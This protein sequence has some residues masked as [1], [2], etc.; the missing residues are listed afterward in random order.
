[1]EKPLFRWTPTRR[2]V[3][4]VVLALIMLAIPATRVFMADLDQVVRAHRE[5]AGLPAVHDL[6]QLVRM[7]Q[8]HRGL[9]NGMLSGNAALA[10]GTR[11][12]GKA[13]DQAL[14]QLTLRPLDEPRLRYQLNL[15]STHWQELADAVGSRTISP[16]ASFQRHTDLIEDELGLL[17]T[18]ADSTGLSTHQEPAGHYLQTAVLEHLPQ[19][20]ESLGRLRGEGTLILSRQ[21]ASLRDRVQLAAETERARETLR[22]VLRTLSL[23][24]LDRHAPLA[25][26]IADADAATASALE[27]ADRS[28]LQTDAPTMPAADYFARMTASID[29][30]FALIDT[31]LAT[32]QLR[33]QGVR[34]AAEA[35]LAVGALGAI[36]LACVGSW[37]LLTAQRAQKA[38]E[39][40]DRRL[41]S[42]IK[43]TPS[44]LFMADAG[45][46]IIEANP[47]ALA[48]FGDYHLEQPLGSLFGTGAAPV[49]LALPA[50][51]D[52]AASPIFVP[53]ATCQRVDGSSFIAELTWIPISAH[54]RHDRH[55]FLAVRDVTER[56]QLQQRLAQSQKMEAIG[57]LTGGIAHDFN[58]MLGVIL[59]NLDL[60]E[61][62]KCLD[63]SALKRIGTAQKAALRGAD[64]T[65]RLLAFS[66][67]Q[68]LD[69]TV[70]KLDEAI[71]EVVEMAARTLGADIHI[72]NRATADAPSVMVDAS[73]FENMLL[74]LLMNARDAMP[75][76]GLIDIA[77]S[78][79]D[80]DARHPAVQ[81]GELSPGRYAS[82]R[83]TDTGQGIAPDKLDKV[84]EPFFTTKQPG[85]GTGLGLAMV[86]G[87]IKQSGG[88]IKLYSE[89]GTGTTVQIILP[90]ADAAA[91]TAPAPMTANQEEHHA[92]PGAIA[93]V[94]DDEPDMRE[95]AAAYLED[96]GY[97][98]LHAGDA[99]DALRVL[100]AEPGISLLVTDVI[101]P[102]GMNGA[103]LG[104][105][106]HHRRPDI[107]V[108][109][110][111]GFPS[112]ALAR[113]NGTQVH[114]PLVSKPFQRQ[115]LVC[116]L[117]RTMDGEVAA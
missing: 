66:R 50:V 52:A 70:L 13:V 24:G 81:A 38:Q 62:S 98:V 115:E 16:E 74:N 65:R 113:R 5:V 69:P 109:Y 96:M 36:V 41:R 14:Q 111:S 37:L 19:L 51:A 6:L 26:A 90:L 47:A 57:Q 87:F 56:A 35:R 105:L 42:I 46:T 9:S 53:E 84:F 110:T 103:K 100:A 58:N 73:G 18:V 86:Y 77:V 34:H 95:V 75:D 17:A 49:P 21:Q 61:R 55:M 76:G 3:S 79:T 11:E 78:T 32:L 99:A 54:D 45:G 71:G 106:V 39:N 114:G 20:A 10:A 63:E 7:T 48:L 29:A 23:S 1:M 2:R 89:V 82:L 102:G 92:A 83:I 72:D 40:S 30:Q 12:A 67:R 59:G 4:I 33:L 44:A 8:R 22:S 60:V 85:H 25:P 43:T 116:A 101:M 88:H 64:L 97:R 27:L 104:Q 68:H 91:G 117:N 15:L 108:V 94:V 28:I 31:A 107:R 93:L 80:I 112:Q